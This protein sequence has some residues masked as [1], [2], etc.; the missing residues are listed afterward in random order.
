MQGGTGKIF[1]L[2][3]ATLDEVILKISIHTFQFRANTYHCLPF[4][5]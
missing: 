5:K 4:F 1:S 2:K 3:Q